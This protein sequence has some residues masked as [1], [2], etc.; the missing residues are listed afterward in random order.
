MKPCKRFAALGATLF[1]IFSLSSCLEK[2]RLSSSTDN[3]LS[4]VDSLLESSTAQSSSS[5]TE[6]TPEASSSIE[7]AQESSVIEN[8]SQESADSATDSSATDR[9]PDIEPIEPT[10]TSLGVGAYR[11]ATNGEGVFYTFAATAGTYT[12]SWTSENAF[13]TIDENAAEASPYAFTVGSSGVVE[14]WF[15]TNGSPDEDTYIVV[16]SKVDE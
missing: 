6:S 9:K 2:Q 4:E 10:G 15:S 1:A 7:S 12:L 3:S 16:I 14:M 5:A 11:I 13:I 8:G